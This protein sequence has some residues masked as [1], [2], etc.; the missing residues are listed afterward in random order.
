MINDENP[1]THKANVEKGLLP[2]LSDGT[3]QDLVEI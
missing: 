1:T 2:F 3:P